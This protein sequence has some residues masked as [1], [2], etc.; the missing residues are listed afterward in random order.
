MKV[1]LFNRFVEDFTMR[2]GDQ[3]AQ[4]ILEWTKT[5]L[6]KKVADCGV[7]GTTRIHL[8]LKR[9]PSRQLGNKASWSALVNMML[10]LKGS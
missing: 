3:I 5:S 6:V 4:I 2:L 7:V 10:V 1:I 8:G 9:L